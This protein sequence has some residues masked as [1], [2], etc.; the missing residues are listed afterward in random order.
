MN[1]YLEVI[2]GSGQVAVVVKNL[3]AASMTIAKGIKV[4]Q[5]VAANVVHPVKLTPNTLEKLNEIQG[6]QWNKMMVG[7]RKKLLFQ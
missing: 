3:T 7:E 5:V 4:A 2:S 6:T 1:T